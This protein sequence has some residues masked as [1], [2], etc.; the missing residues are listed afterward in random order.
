M[1]SIEIDRIIKSGV[2]RARVK[3]VKGAIKHLQ[4]TR[5]RLDFQ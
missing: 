3:P 1:H 4:F 5:V 2:K